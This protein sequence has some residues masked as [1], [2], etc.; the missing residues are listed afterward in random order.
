[1]LVTIKR[2]KR[3]MRRLRGRRGRSGGYVVLSRGVNANM[4]THVDF[5]MMSK[6]DF[7]LKPSILFCPGAALYRLFF[8]LLLG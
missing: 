1:M 2:K 8:C 3:K 4:V 6:Y 5:P 7:S